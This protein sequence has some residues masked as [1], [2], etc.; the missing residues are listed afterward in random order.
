MKEAYKKQFVVCGDNG[1]PLAGQPSSGYTLWQ[2]M[3]RHSREVR[4]A[5]RLFG[6]SA[7]E[8]DRWFM[9]Y[10]LDTWEKVL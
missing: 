4:E 8:A 7:K 1:V 5:V 10:K 6:V 3:E 9:V 2:A